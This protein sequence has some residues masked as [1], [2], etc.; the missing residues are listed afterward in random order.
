[1]LKLSKLTA[2]VW[3]KDVSSYEENC[4]EKKIVDVLLSGEF[5]NMLENDLSTWHLFCCINV[6]HLFLFIKSRMNKKPN[7]LLFLISIQKNV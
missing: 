7:N 2:S 4:E 3:A 5:L 1:M 6:F